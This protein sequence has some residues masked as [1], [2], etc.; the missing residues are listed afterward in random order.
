MLEDLKTDQEL[1]KRGV[2]KAAPEAVF[3]IASN[4]EEFE[5]KINW[6]GPDIILADYNVPGYNGLEALLLVREK[7][8][9]VPFVFVT[10]SLNDEEKVAETILNGASGYILKGNLSELP[11][12]IEH[13]LVREEK[14]F[15]ER[16]AQVQKQR[17]KKLLLQKLNALIENS[18]E[19][20]NK[21][22]AVDIMQE[23]LQITGVQ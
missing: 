23:V 22:D 19:F 16:E 12:K 4:Q 2:L 10:G 3:I 5:D 6:V 15:K 8:P 13:V 18:S 17:R 1:I 9:H 14:R 11:D 21:K 7:M 20:S